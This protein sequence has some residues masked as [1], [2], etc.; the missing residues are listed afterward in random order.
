M[1]SSPNIPAD[2][3]QAI[4]ELWRI[5]P[6]GPPNLLSHPS[7]LRLST[8]CQTIYGLKHAPKFALS[9][10]LRSLGLPYELP[11]EISH[12][13][14]DPA[15]AA[16]QL[17][18]A[19]R[20]T[21]STRVHLCPLDLL[22]ELPALKFG[23]NSIERLSKEQLEALVNPLKLK[24]HN[25]A[26]HFDAK[27]FSEFHWLIVREE[28]K[29]NFEPEERNTPFWFLSLDEDL[30]R[31]IPHPEKFPPAVEAALFMLMLAPW[32]DWT[33]MHEV[34][35]RAF[36]IPWVY[37][38]DNDLFV[39]PNA[40][41]SPD[42]LSWEYA[43][44]TDSDGDEVEYE[45]PTT[46]PVLDGVNFAPDWINDDAW[47]SLQAVKASPLFETPI[48]H[49]LV[50]AFLEDG[51]DSFLAHITAIDAALGL[52]EDH[53]RKERR[54]LTQLP[55]KKQDPGATVRIAARL[56]GLLN[57][58]SV[59]GDFERIFN[60]RSNYLH[61]RRMEPIPTEERI[62]ARKLARQACAALVREAL[63]SDKRISREGYLDQFLDKGLAP[64]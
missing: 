20:Q 35:W 62:L 42:A 61:G 19:F 36:R 53:N 46:L 49:F 34:D 2:F 18:A 10:A 28:I 59:G 51:I 31:I 13:A 1:T 64:T 3:L 52:E 12:L 37:S 17:D 47:E 33:G 14:S 50:R 38:I 15:L 8:I 58:K 29:N 40:P 7:F 4:T 39:R 57:S 26:W 45:R 56:S 22:D 41:P 27:R 60:S 30:G 43:S 6:P 54:K 32:E 24:R 5:N 9:T 55:R 25:S 11:K 63:D 44:Y 16:A 48:S 23:P 21:N